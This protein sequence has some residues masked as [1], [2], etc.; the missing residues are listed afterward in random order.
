[1]IGCSGG[2]G[3]IVVI[4]VFVVCVVVVIVGDGIGVVI[5]DS[6]WSI[7]CRCGCGRTVP[8]LASHIPASP[9]KI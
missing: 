1:M 4:G 2:D 6:L 3:V 5:E 7:W 8:L 9:T